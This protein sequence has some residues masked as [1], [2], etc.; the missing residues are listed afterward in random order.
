M[1]IGDKV[2]IKEG[3]KYGQDFRFPFWG[4][5]KTVF[6]IKE[7]SRKNLIFL[8][9]PGYGEKGNYGNGGV[10]VYGENSLELVEKKNP[11]T[12]EE[13]KAKKI[14]LFE[15]QF[16]NISGMIENRGYTGT[17]EELKS[18][19]SQTIDELE[20]IAKEERM[21]AQAEAQLL[22]Y[23]LCAE[24]YSLSELVTSMG[25]TKKELK[26]L[27]KTYSLE[28]LDRMEKSECMTL[29]EIIKGN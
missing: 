16:C 2:R 15:R 10:S 21:L 25:L 29:E 28:Y 3:A 13:Y 26:Q 8:V 23:S 1:K 20:E 24:G 11:I 9:A 27:R 14:D 18:F 6:T 22:G 19:L 12:K 4:K 7:I 5:N 17:K